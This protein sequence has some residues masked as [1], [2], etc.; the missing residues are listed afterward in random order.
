[1]MNFHE[2]WLNPCLSLPKISAIGK[3]K[4]GA[5]WKGCG[6]IADNYLNIHNLRMERKGPQKRDGM[7]RI[8]HFGLSKDKVLM[9]T[10]IYLE[11]AP[12]WTYY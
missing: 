12:F 11:C 6:W 3:S 4:D 10:D 7:G 2:K 5:R 8:V 9:I 1:M